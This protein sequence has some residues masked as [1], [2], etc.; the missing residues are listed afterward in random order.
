MASDVTNRVGDYWGRRSY[1]TVVE[2][3]PGRD[4]SVLKM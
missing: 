4:T 2:F 3:R 1:S